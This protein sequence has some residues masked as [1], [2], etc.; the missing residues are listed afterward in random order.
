MGQKR[1]GRYILK[2]KLKVEIMCMTWYFAKVIFEIEISAC[3]VRKTGD[4]PDFTMTWCCPRSMLARGSPDHVVSTGK[5]GFHFLCFQR[6][7]TRKEK[8]R[9]EEK[10]SGKPHLWTAFIKPTPPASRP[11]HA[12]G[13]WELG[14]ST[15]CDDIFCLHVRQF[16]LWLSGTRNE[17]CYLRIT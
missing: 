4:I 5:K 11:G 13:N 17:N 7:N 12:D 2:N 15:M 16:Y 10:N 14:E 8:A 9:A 6:R 1:E 3:N